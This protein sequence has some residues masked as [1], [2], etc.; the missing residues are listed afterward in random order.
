MFACGTTS[1]PQLLSGL[2]I[3][4]HI[5]LRLMSYQMTDNLPTDPS[6]TLEEYKS[7]VLERRFVMTSYIQAIAFYVAVVGFSG[8]QYFAVHT[9]SQR[10]F[11]L[12][13]VIGVNTLAWLTAGKF[14]KLAYHAI[15]RETLLAQS[16]GMQAPYPLVWGYQY[17]L[18]MGAIIQ[19]GAVTEL[20]R[21]LLLPA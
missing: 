5:Q 20:I 14:R 21:Q 15:D 10:L 6:I 1:R 19:I 13:F 2:I 17:A 3:S 12:A 18:G 9:R 16:L 7:L 4:L 8:G 11:L